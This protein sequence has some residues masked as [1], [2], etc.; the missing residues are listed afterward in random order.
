M[1]VADLLG[2]GLEYTRLRLFSTPG[3]QLSASTLSMGEL[4]P[5]WSIVA[6]AFRDHDIPGTFNFEK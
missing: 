6:Q 1:H 3:A 5:V 2:A 4:C